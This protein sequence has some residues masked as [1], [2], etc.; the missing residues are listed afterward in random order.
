MEI[1]HF[2]VLTD[3]FAPYAKASILGSTESLW[4]SSITEDGSTVA[5]GIAKQAEKLS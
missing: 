2:A 4:A 3:S 5:G 1:F